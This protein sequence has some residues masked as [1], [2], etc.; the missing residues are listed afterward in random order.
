MLS[1]FGGSKLCL[2]YNLWL[3]GCKVERT[4]SVICIKAA[5]AFA[6][7]GILR[8]LKSYRAFL[9]NVFIG[10]A[11]HQG[12]HQYFTWRAAP[13][14]SDHEPRDEKHASRYQQLVF[15]E[16]RSTLSPESPRASESYLNSKVWSISF[17]IIYTV[18]DN[19]LNRQFHFSAAD[20]LNLQGSKTSDL[21]LDIRYSLIVC[22]LSTRDDRDTL[23]TI[24]I[25]VQRH[26]DIAVPRILV[27]PLR[28]WTYIVKT[29]STQCSSTS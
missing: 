5:Q 1:Q 22:S 2:E 3:N 4:P 8:P 23:N 28:E 17:V 16:V 15:F 29:L 24:L 14:H 7:S 9:C 19:L 25:W 13:W 10:E 27:V 12:R 20:I 26:I 21:L 18:H 11:P 6:V